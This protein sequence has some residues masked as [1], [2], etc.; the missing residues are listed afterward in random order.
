[1]GLLELLAAPVLAPIKGL[2]W[3]AEKVTEQ[4]D[5]ELYNEDAI[6]GQLM[7]LELHLELGEI[8]QEEYLADEEVLLERLRVIRERQAAGR[9]E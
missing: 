4:A 7:E 1:M 6:R 2:M 8:S 3:I 5:R 9:E